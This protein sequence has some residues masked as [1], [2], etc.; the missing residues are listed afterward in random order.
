MNQHEFESQLKAEGYSTI[1]PIDR[2]V[3]YALDE[4]QHTFDACALVTRGDFTLT[5]DSVATN[6]AVGQ[7]FRL[8]A[9]TPHHE[10]AGPVGVSYI[11]GRRE[12]AAP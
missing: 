11:S 4:H 7:I 6:Y 2:P 8:P 5:V 12:M 1:T 10:C 9:G 3:G